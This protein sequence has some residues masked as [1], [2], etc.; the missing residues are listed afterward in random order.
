VGVYGDGSDGAVTVSS[1]ADW[2]QSPPATTLQF[3][4]FAVSAGVTLTVPS[5]TVIRATGNVTISGNIVV[6]KVW[7]AGMGAATSAALCDTTGTQPGIYGVGLG[8]ANALIARQLVNPGRRGGG[9]GG[10]ES[11]GGGGQ[12]GGTLVILASGAI[13]IHSG[14]SISANG[15][16]GLDET[17]VHNGGGGGGGII[18]LASRTSIA[19]SGV[20]NVWG[21][22]GGSLSVS[23]CGGSTASTGGGGGGGGLIN[24]LAPSISAGTA[25][26]AGGAGGAGWS[27]A[28]GCGGGGGGSYGDGGFS[29]AGGINGSAGAP[30]AVLTTIIQDPSTLFAPAAGSN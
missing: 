9:G 6:A 8:D 21:G 28:T 27:G 14:G 13:T 11:E 12:G 25:S 26:V 2:T 3:T 1:T 17:M 10:C 18:V 29:G 5:G 16:A 30:G 7:N 4:S 20:L 19:N 23:N 22:A 24:L 15:T